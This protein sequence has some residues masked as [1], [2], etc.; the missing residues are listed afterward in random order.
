VGKRDCERRN[1]YLRLG[2]AGGG[3]EVELPELL[4]QGDDAFKREA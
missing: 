3:G 2:G 1:V 4:G